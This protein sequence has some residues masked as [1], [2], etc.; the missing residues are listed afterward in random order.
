MAPPH[1]EMEILLDLAMCGDMAGLMSRTSLMEAMDVKYQ[2]FARM[3]RDLAR[4][5]EDEKILSLMKE[6]TKG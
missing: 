2:P 3:L 4:A 1:E 5:F 6:Y